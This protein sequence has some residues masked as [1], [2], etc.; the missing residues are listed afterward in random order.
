MFSFDLSRLIRNEWLQ[1]RTWG[2]CSR[3][4]HQRIHFHGKNK[5]TY[6]GVNSISNLPAARDGLVLW[7][8]GVYQKLFQVTIFRSYRHLFQDHHQMTIQNGLI[9][10]L[11]LAWFLVPPACQKPSLQ[12]D[13]E[14]GQKCYLMLWLSVF[15]QFIFNTI[16]T[17]ERTSLNI[18]QC[19][20][21]LHVFI[22][23]MEFHLSCPRYNIINKKEIAETGIPW[24]Q[25]HRLSRW[26][27]NWGWYEQLVD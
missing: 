17:C 26:K 27:M 3:H 19:D 6:E 23:P 20:D 24:R 7:S 4:K 14:N 25:N 11:R 12:P 8:R 21:E 1:W 18:Q 10:F 16:M 9:H 13:H 15:H 22:T 5:V 2:S